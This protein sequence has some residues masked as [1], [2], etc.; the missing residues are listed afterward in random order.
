MPASRSPST[1]RLTGARS[2]WATTGWPASSAGIRSRTARTASAWGVEDGPASRSHRAAAERAGPAPPRCGGAS[3]RA[4]P[5]ARREAG[6]RITGQSAQPGG[7]GGR[8]EQRIAG[9][10]GEVRGHREWRVRPCVAV[11]NLRH[12]QPGRGRSEG[13]RE[14][15]PAGDPRASRDRRVTLLVDDPPAILEGHERRPDAGRPRPGQ[16][17]D[18]EYATPEQRGRHVHPWSGRSSTNIPAAS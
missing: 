8:G 13:A 4:P 14:P 10:A 16:V 17:L 15:D 6:R 9:L 12:R 11:E 2:P 1:R 18:P 7:T 5:A 3:A